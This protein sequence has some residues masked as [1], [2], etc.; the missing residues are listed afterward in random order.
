MNIFVVMNGQSHKW[1]WM[2]RANNMALGPVVSQHLVAC[3]DLIYTKTILDLSVVS[4]GGKMEVNA[5][6]IFNL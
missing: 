4:G 3:C 6:A 2:V 5:V 1:G